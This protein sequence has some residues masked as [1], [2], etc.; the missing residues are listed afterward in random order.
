[1]K[2]R[3]LLLSAVIILGLIISIG[4]VAAVPKLFAFSFWEICLWMIVAMSSI[5]VTIVS[6]KSGEGELTSHN[7]Y[8]TEFRKVLSDKSTLGSIVV[9]LTVVSLIAYF[10]MKSEGGGV[11]DS[12]SGQNTGVI[13]GD[14]AGQPFQTSEATKCAL[15]SDALSS[16]TVFDINATRQCLDQYGCSISG[17]I[18]AKLQKQ[19]PGIAVL[20]EISGAFEGYG[21]FKEALQILRLVE[22]SDSRR[23]QYVRWKQHLCQRAE[24]EQYMTD[25]DVQKLLSGADIDSRC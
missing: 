1:M 22:P 14:R 20:T 4:A 16:T 11:R 25:L 18:E 10:V 19:N 21:C 23:L 7:D 6:L 17:D 8:A 3:R 24:F 2:A 9:T 5:V 15:R 13:S 12:D